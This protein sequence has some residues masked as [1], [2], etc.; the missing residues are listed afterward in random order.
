MNYP[1]K[2]NQDYLEQAR[3]FFLIGRYGLEGR[4]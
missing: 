2:I 4:I 1:I 3:T